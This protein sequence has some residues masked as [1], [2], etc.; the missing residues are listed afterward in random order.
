MVTTEEAQAQIGA[1]FAGKTLD[2]QKAL[3]AA[4]ERGGAAVYRSLAEQE[5]DA[6]KRDELLAAALKEEENADVLEKQIAS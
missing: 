3:L 5:P 6:A 1:L 2:E 4:L